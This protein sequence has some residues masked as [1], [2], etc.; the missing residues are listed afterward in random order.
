VNGE[1]YVFSNE[2]LAAGDALFKAFFHIQQII[3]TVYNRISQEDLIDISLSD[4]IIELGSELSIFDHKWVTFEQL[5]VLELMI[6]ESDARRY[7]SDAIKLEKELVS[8]EVRERA[9]GRVLLNWDE[10]NNT[11]RK[12]TKLCGQINAVAN[13]DG[14]GRDDLEID[15]LIAAESMSRRISNTQSKAVRKLADQIRKAFMNL[16]LLFRKY[17]ENIEVV[18]PQLKN[19]PDLVEALVSFETSWEKGKNYFIDPTKCR[20]L[21]SISEIIEATAEKHPT[22]QE[23]I[24]C[25]D[26]DVFMS[27]PRLA[28][29]KGL[30]DDDDS[31]SCKDFYPPMYTQGDVAYEKFSKLTKVY[32]ESR[33]KAANAYDFYNVIECAI[34]EISVGEEKRRS[35]KL[36]DEE[37]DYMVHMIKQL[38]VE[39]QR[40]NPTEWNGFLDVCLA[41]VY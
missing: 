12:L 3:R 21:I 26:S 32:R 14:K 36:T 1:K 4:V 6:I 9:K 10:Y 33:N 15:I 24:E 28:I 13:A 35:S 17:Q 27:I 22:L 39:L 25:R 8:M 38:A 29:L 31:G 11:R 2:V 34:L 18:D 16:R 7:I 40:F 30:D 23:Q 19:N 20:Q 5:Y 37:V 41:D